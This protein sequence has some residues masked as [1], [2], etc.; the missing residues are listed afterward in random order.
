MWLPSLRE[1]LAL[2]SSVCYYFGYGGAGRHGVGHCYFGYDEAG[3]YDVA[4]CYF[5]SYGVLRAEPFP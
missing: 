5:F 3:R 1:V 2:I 4:L